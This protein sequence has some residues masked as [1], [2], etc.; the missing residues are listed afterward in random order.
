MRHRGPDTSSYFIIESLSIGHTRLSIIDL[1]E[2]GTQPFVYEHQGRKVY[3]VYNGEVYNFKDLKENLVEKGYS[4]SSNTDTEVL[5]EL[6]SKFGT[7]CFKLLKGIFAFI[8]FDNVKKKVYCARDRLGVKPL[9]Y[10]K[11]NN[12]D[13]SIIS[14][15][16]EKQDSLEKYTKY[17][18][19]H[20]SNCMVF[21]PGDRLKIFVLSSPTL[22]KY[23][24]ALS[25]IPFF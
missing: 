20:I 24:R 9:Y 19:N 16:W 6:F 14:R 25:K 22:E 11:N 23:S 2:R 21:L 15:F 5:I 1:S 7:D 12:V 13:N 4:F 10:I 17:W 18:E 3:I 8:I